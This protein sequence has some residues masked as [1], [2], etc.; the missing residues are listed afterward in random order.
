[1]EGG[2]RLASAGGRLTRPTA[3]EIDMSY[4]HV[5]NLSSF[6]KRKKERAHARLPYYKNTNFSTTPFP[7]VLETSISLSNKKGQSRRT[8][9]HVFFNPGYKDGR[10]RS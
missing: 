9:F 6:K 3:T 4:P 5:R 8:K 2:A 10:S 1:M 7:I